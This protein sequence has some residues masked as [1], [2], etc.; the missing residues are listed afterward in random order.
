MMAGVKEKSGVGAAGAGGA[1]AFEPKLKPDEAPNAGAEGAAG[2]AP[3]AI[4]ANGL[5]LAAGALVPFVMDAL[6]A[7]VEANG[8]G[9]D[10]APPNPPNPPANGEGFCVGHPGQLHWSA[11]GMAAYTHR[12][13]LGSW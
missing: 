2:V 7:A 1:A 10:E 4:D 3:N 6:D 13:G 12:C 9:N 8:F 11:R 5:G